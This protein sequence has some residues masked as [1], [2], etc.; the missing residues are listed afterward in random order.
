MALLNMLLLTGLAV[1][2][3][4]TMT[5]VLCLDRRQLRRTIGEYDHRL[6]DV[7]PYLGAAALFF[8]TKR[9]THDYSVKLSHAL[10][11]DITAELYTV[12]G[13]FVA[14]LQAIVPRSTLE[15]FSVMYMFG[16]PFLLVTAP[17][18]YFALSSQ[19][20]LKELLI[21]YVF[22]YAIGAI[23]YTLFIAYGPRNH[24]STVDGLMYSFYPQTQDMTAAVSANTDVFPSLHTS[25]AVVVL[26]FAWRS[27]REYPRWLPIAAFVAAS[28]VFSTMY[29]GIHWLSDVVAGIVLGVGSVYAAERIVARAEGDAD[30]VSV[31]GE[32]D[33][34]IASDAS[35]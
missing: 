21:A 1:L 17:I 26:L 3:G 2:A 4:L 13:E 24:L 29:L 25:L 20:H 11:W 28:V 18:L 5:C 16:F 32:R 9:L 8:L 7:A 14:H 23:C 22:N 15:F 33:E 6:R 12:E 27:R 31:P 34:G 30:R 35:D 19:R 10:D